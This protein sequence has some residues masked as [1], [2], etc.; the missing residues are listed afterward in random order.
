M[1]KFHVRITFPNFDIKKQNRMKH[2]PHHVH[3]QNQE[4]KVFKPVL[5]LQGLN[6]L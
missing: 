4:Q 2:L 3:P 1:R 6:L 5:Q